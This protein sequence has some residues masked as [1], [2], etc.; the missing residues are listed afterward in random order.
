M[1]VLVVRVTALMA[2][3]KQVR[4]LPQDL[5]ARECG[6][7][8]VGRIHARNFDDG[9][10]PS[11]G[12]VQR[13]L[14]EL[15]RLAVRQAKAAPA[16]PVTPVRSELDDLRARRTGSSRIPDTTDRVGPAVGDHRR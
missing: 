11:G 10:S 8:E 4:Q 14:A 5:Q 16:S 1:G 3:N 15:R 12:G 9:H 13:V 7:I 2:Y 6:L